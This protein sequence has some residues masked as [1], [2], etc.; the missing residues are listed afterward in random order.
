MKSK[1][2]I[3]LLCGCVFF[4]SMSFE[5]KLADIPDLSFIEDT[6]SYTQE[7][8]LQLTKTS[9][10]KLLTATSNDDEAVKLTCESF[11]AIAKAS[12]REPN[13]YD[14][15]V[16]VS[17]NSLNKDTIQYRLTDYIYQSELNEAI[18]QSISNDSLEFTDFKITYN[19]I[20]ATASIV[21]SYTYYSNDGFDDKS[22][23]RKMYTFTLHNINNSWLITD[24][25]TDDPWE[26][27]DN[28]V[29]SPINVKATI[30]EI[31]TIK[32]NQ[33]FIN[34]DKSVQPTTDSTMY[35]WTYDT[36]AAVDYAEN[37]YDD[38][39]SSDSIFGYTSG[40]DC[41]N[42]ASQCV[43][44]GLGGSGSST[45][46]RPAVPTS[47]AGSDAFNVWC[48]N[49]HT[50]NYSSYY[51]NWAWDN[52]RGFMKLLKASSSSSEGPYGNSYYSDGVENS[53]VG[54]V[55]C[56]NWDGTPDEDS[57]DHAM[58]VTEVSGTS[59][60]RTK[61]DVKIAAHTSATNSAYEKLSSYTTTS[62]NNFGR[63]EIWRGYYT[64]EQP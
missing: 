61:S 14:P 12:V 46:D 60:S 23:R 30:S 36:S 38:T 3:I 24:V 52:A 47:R 31:A 28:F 15:S 57:M 22:F 16:I 6:T 1:L 49:Q 42:F 4:S 32:S 27:E 19:G 13:K 9:N 44:A 48:R 56:V 8:Y 34:K 25:K 64:V 41:Q 18:N 33:N 63:S 59:G 55:L 26:L 51:F 29:Y 10:N 43:W 50:T 17:S 54:N 40:N 21:E 53:E 5:S 35:S 37:H 20:E 11:L 39:S 58:F 7:Q 2:F 45:T 62:I